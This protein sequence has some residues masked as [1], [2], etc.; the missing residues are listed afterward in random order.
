MWLELTEGNLSEWCVSASVRLTPCEVRLLR[1][2]EGSKE[3]RVDR[4]VGPE[5]RGC[6]C[7]MLEMVSAILVRSELR[8]GGGIE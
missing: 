3:P 7:C 1:R 8:K 5:G 4:G 2:A 6:C